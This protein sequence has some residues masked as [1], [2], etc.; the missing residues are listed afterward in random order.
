[1]CS[2]STACQ[3]VYRSDD[4][5]HVDGN[6]CRD[7]GGYSHHGGE[8]LLLPRAVRRRPWHDD[9][10]AGTQT[11]KNRHDGVLLYRLHQRASG[12]F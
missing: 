3:L 10:D 4:G 7:G 2:L 9:A 11:I 6:V 8:T 5:S 12:I 1:M